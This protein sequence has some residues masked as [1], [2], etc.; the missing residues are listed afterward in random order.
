M[1]LRM[2]LNIKPSLPNH[3]LGTL[4]VLNDICTPYLVGGCVRDLFRN[5]KPKDFD[6][7]Q[8]KDINELRE[9]LMHSGFIIN[10]VGTNFKVLFVQS[11]LHTYEISQYRK[12]TKYDG[13]HATVESGD[14][15]TDAFRRDFTVNALY[16]N[17]FSGEVLDPTKMGI[18]D[19]YKNILRFIGNP[20]DRIEEDY[21]RVFRFY[22]FLSKGF[23][24]DKKSLKA[25]RQYFNLAYK[26]TT[27]ERVRMELE[28]IITQ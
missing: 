2:I 27:P 10:E 15:N 8:D 26:N 6:I 20:K 22:R 1:V 3:L 17:P 14:I 25:C 16:Y 12:D 5:K 7:V 11:G 9:P 18:N 28:K 19:L 24:A 4:L 13:R 21:L 23:E